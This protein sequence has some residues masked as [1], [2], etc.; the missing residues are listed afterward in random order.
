MTLWLY[1]RIKRALCE[2][3]IHIWLITLSVWRRVEAV[4]CHCLLPL[5]EENKQNR[6]T[7]PARQNEQSFAPRLNLEGLNENEM[8]A[9]MIMKWMTGT[10]N[11][12]MG[13]LIGYYFQLEEKFEVHPQTCVIQAVLSLS[14]VGRTPLFS[15]PFSLFVYYGWKWPHSQHWT[16]DFAQLVKV[17]Y[18]SAMEIMSQMATWPN[19]H[20]GSPTRAW[21]HWQVGFLICWG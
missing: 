18:C 13:I 10:W 17:L 8:R 16:L 7:H 21:L 11:R 19:G 9:E 12:V 6:L 14:S 3:R 1:S 20:C 4:K 15:L 2:K 5:W